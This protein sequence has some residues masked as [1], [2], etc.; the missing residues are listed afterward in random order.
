[1]W[2][3]LLSILSLITTDTQQL[4]LAVSPNSPS[5]MYWKVLPGILDHL[6]LP[7]F[8]EIHEHPKRRQREQNSHL[9]KHMY[10]NLRMMLWYLKITAYLFPIE[11]S[12]PI[13]SIF[14]LRDSKGQQSGQKRS[15]LHAYWETN[16]MRKSNLRRNYSTLYPGNPLAP[17]KRLDSSHWHIKDRTWIRLL[18]QEGAVSLKTVI[19]YFFSCFQLYN[20]QEVI[21][22]I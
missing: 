1:M 11:S 14:S 18:E 2:L 8:Q 21:D 22:G 13:S 9:K 20:H 15:L 3:S 6:F 10:I 7:F 17:C 12:N 5:L 16:A 19:V 4:R